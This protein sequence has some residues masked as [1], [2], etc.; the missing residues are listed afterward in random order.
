[1]QNTMADGYLEGSPTV[2]QQVG[3]LLDVFG[4]KV[5]IIDHLVAKLA[6]LGDAAVVA[7]Q[8]S[9]ECLVFFH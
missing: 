5:S 1:M 4:C 6:H 7:G 8:F 9:L 2:R 3:A